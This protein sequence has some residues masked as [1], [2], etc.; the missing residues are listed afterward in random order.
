L[1]V[2]ADGAKRLSRVCAATL[3]CSD[4][5][6]M[7]CSGAEDSPPRKRGT[8]MAMRD[9]HKI[10][11]RPWAERADSPSVD[12][13]AHATQISFRQVVL[14]MFGEVA[15]WGAEMPQCIHCFQF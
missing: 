14:D 8:T 4:V 1:I 13:V 9:F 11:L 5:E 6:E 10:L 7:F 2:I 3:R 12:E 15:R